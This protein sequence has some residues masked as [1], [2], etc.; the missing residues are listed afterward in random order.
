M[1]G[2]VKWMNKL[3][4]IRFKKNKFKGIY[5]FFLKVC[6]IKSKIKNIIKIIIIIKIVFLIIN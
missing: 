2:I 3:K 5:L 1:D 4:Y 6:K